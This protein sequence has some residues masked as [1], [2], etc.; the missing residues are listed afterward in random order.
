MKNVLPT[1][2][3]A[4]LK[5]VKSIWNKLQLWYVYDMKSNITAHFPQF[6]FK[7][8]KKFLW[9]PITKRTHEIRPEEKVRLRTLEFLT[10]GLGW[11]A[12]RIASEAKIDHAPTAQTLRADLI[13]Y[14]KEMK[15]ELLVECKAESVKLNESAAVQTARYNTTVKASVMLITNGLE[16]FWIG[17]NGEN[18][19]VLKECPYPIKPA[20]ELHS[21]LEYW[22]KRGFAGNNAEG[23]LK[24]WLGKA[25]PLFWSDEQPWPHR[26]LDLKYQL[27][28]V[29]PDH[30][31]RLIQMDDDTRLAVGF[32]GSD[33]G[34]SYL[35]SIL[36][37]NQQ[38]TGLLVISLDDVAAGNSENSS[39]LSINTEDKIDIRK[40]VPIDITD[41]NPSIVENLPGF[42]ARFFD[43]K[44]SL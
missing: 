41:W 30:Y 36:N 43:K 39:L 34:K 12:S 27:R 2:I 23:V 9:N 8:G 35:I 11:P 7:E 26:Y 38:N 10:H 28:D 24:E 31:Y 29:Q 5:L 42:I 16:D 1:K 17:F 22:Q 20:S 4:S 40:Y 44:L 32:V 3:V 18:A 14:S 37:K 15:P 33:N 21:D 25:I 6:V 19:E 13:A